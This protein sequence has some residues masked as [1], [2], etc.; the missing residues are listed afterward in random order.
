MN[1]QSCE[2][3]HRLTGQL[4]AIERMVNEGRPCLEL[5]QQLRAVRSSVAGLEK[6]IIAAELKKSLPQTDKTDTMN[7]LLDNLIF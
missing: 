6:S 5:V 3:L 2:H 4:A 1:K 7:K